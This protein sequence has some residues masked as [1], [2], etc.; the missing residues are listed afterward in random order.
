M[1]HFKKEQKKNYKN[2]A[3]RFINIKILKYNEQVRFTLSKYLKYYILF[4]QV[5]I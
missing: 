5:E 1:K 4:I 3:S 2:N